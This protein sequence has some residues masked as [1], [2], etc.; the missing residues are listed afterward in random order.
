MDKGSIFT[1]GQSGGTNNVNNHS[2]PVTYNNGTLSGVKV[3]VTFKKVTWSIISVSVALSAAVGL[4]FMWP[5]ISGNQPPKEATTMSGPTI[6]AP[7][8]IATINQQGGT[9]T[10]VNQAPPKLTFSVEIGQKLLK[11]IPKDKPVTVVAVGSIE[12]QRVGQQFADYLMKQGYTVQ[13][14][15]V[16]VLG[17]PPNKPLE[18]NGYQLIVAP[19]VRE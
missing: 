10:V 17:P 5:T 8:G 2:G 6:N 9:N 15:N 11:E 7:G 16:G 14:H 3:P 19:S 18:W 12:D 1:A 4:Y 13:S